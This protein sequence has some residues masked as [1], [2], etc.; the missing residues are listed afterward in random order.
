MIEFNHLSELAEALHKAIAEHVAKTA[1]D[2]MTGAVE[3]SPDATGFLESS[4]YV[5]THEGSTYGQGVQAPPKGATLLPEVEKPTNDQEALIAVGA[6]YGEYVELGTSK[7]SARPYLYPSIDAAQPAFA[8][9]DLEELLAK[10][11]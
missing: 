4:V 1:K 2:V 11:K 8:S 3:R 9:P 7:M 5:S 10:V 6:S